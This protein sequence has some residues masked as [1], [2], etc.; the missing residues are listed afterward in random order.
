[1]AA[2]TKTGQTPFDFLV[3][4]TRCDWGD[5]DADDE[6]ANDQSLVDGSRV[7]SAYTLNDGTRI[8]FL[9]EAVG[10]D[11]RRAATCALLPEEY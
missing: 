10:D 5:V 4:H 6:R 8:W 2:L 1:M 3:R 11:R 9:T 7:L